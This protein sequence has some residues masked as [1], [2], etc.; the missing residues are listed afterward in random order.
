MNDHVLAQNFFEINQLQK[1]T[2]KILTTKPIKMKKNTLRLQV[3]LILWLVSFLPSIGLGQDS[4]F[5]R[6]IYTATEMKLNWDKFSIDAGWKNLNAELK[7][8]GF[9]RLSNEKTMWGYEGYIID[10]LKNKQPVMFCAFDLARKGYNG[11]ASMIWVKK[12]AQ[13]YKAFIIFP[14]GEKDVEKAFENSTEYYADASDKL[15]KANSFG[16]C[17][18]RECRKDCPSFCLSSITACAT[19]AA[20]I[21]ASGLGITTPVA[22][23]I[24]GGCAGIACIGCL[25]VQ[26][27]QCL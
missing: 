13:L 19:A 11:L 15:Q 6:R 18:R 12:G 5:N 1:G 7:E 24:F 4:V 17:W 21:A 27:I 26:A 3:L 8:K 23:A 2:V 25:A 22:I 9:G 10:S 16:R 14:D 20:T